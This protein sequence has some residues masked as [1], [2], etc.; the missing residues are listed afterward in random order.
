MRATEKRGGGDIQIVEENQ[1]KL[2]VVWY[3]DGRVVTTPPYGE[4]PQDSYP[5]ELGD[6]CWWRETGDIH[7]VIT[8]GVEVSGVSSGREP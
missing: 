1:D 7:G 8:T 5:T 4:I 6:R 2:Q 3:G